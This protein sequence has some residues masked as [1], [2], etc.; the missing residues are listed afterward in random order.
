MSAKITTAF[1]YAVLPAP[2]HEVTV[3]M[4]ECY[5]LFRSSVSAAERIRYAT[6]T[7]QDDGVGK[8]RVQPTSIQIRAFQAKDRFGPVISAA[9]ICLSY[10]DF[11]ENKANPDTISSSFQP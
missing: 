9:K 1:G 3:H 2:H 10:K 7:N 6:S 8:D 4:P 11:K 5:F